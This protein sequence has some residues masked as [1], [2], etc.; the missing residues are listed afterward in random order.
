MNE[1]DQAGRRRV[2]ILSD[3]HGDLDD[4]VADLVS[5]CDLA[6]HGGD[7][8]G[9]SVLARLTPRG[10]RVIAVRGNNDQPRH[11]PVDE[12]QILDCLPEIADVVLPGGQLILIH[13]HQYPAF[14]RHAM[15][16]RRFPQAR[17][18]VYGHSHHLSIDRDQA[19]WILN[20]GAAGRVRTH[21]GASCLIL[22]ATETDWS[23]VVHRFALTPRRRPRPR[24]GLDQS[25]AA[26]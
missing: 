1:P 17:A 25:A 21:G 26:P 23:L 2:A 6:V 24:R 4:R 14:R 13:G 3:T 16:R 10:G 11:W 9:L 5:E 15:L 8:G 12:R 18:V 7:I 22:T 20:P 19:P